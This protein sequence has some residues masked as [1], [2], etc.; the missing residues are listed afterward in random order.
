MRNQ[1]SLHF[2]GP[3]SLLQQNRGR[4]FLFNLHVLDI[5]HAPLQL[6]RKYS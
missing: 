1:V 2:I 5:G 3:S 4:E 6:R